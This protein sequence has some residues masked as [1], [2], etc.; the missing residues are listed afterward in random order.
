MVALSGPPGFDFSGFCA[1]LKRT[2][3]AIEADLS[4]RIWE[5]ENQRWECDQDN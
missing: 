2:S 3:N 4:H 5:E 1:V